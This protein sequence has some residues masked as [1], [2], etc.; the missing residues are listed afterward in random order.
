MYRLPVREGGLAPIISLSSLSSALLEL[1]ESFCELDMLGTRLHTNKHLYN[2]L[3]NSS[4]LR[5]LPLLSV[6]IAGYYAIQ[7]ELFLDLL[8]VER[9]STHPSLA[10]VDQQ[11]YSGDAHTATHLLLSNP[12]IS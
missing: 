10:V 7:L 4:T 5:L 6:L 3:T 11:F 2:S 8:L 9:A 1:A 12:G